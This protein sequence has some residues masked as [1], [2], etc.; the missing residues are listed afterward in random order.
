[1]A[2]WTCPE[3]D[4]ALGSRRRLIYS[5]DVIGCTPIEKLTQYESA[6][7]RNLSQVTT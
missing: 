1:M 6:L 7:G 5:K 3:L 2:E 4:C